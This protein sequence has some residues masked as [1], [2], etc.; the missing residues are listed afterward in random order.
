MF[1]YEIILKV[2]IRQAVLEFTNYPIIERTTRTKEKH[3]VE[4]AVVHRYLRENWGSV[5]DVE[6]VRTSVEQVRSVA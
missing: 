6:V 1:K 5:T 2:T 3:I 4:R